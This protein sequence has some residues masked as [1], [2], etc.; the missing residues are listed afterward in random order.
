MHHDLRLFHYYSV[1]LLGHSILL[2]TVWHSLLVHNTVTLTVPSRV[3]FT[4]LVLLSE[5]THLLRSPHWSWYMV[6]Y[7]SNLYGIFSSSC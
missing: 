7:Y 6:L 4:N 5:R 1:Y 3:L 2:R